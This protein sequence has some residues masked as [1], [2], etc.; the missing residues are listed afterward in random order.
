MAEGG[1]AFP[2]I[3][4]PTSLLQQVVVELD[5]PVAKGEAFR[6]YRVGDG[7]HEGRRMRDEGRRMRKYRTVKG[8]N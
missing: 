4:S 6:L 3:I 8:E 2:H 7:A 5:D 1:F